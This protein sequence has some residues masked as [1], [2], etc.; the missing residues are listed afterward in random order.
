MDRTFIGW[1]EFL[2]TQMFGLGIGGE[3]R[4]L[5]TAAITTHDPA[6]WCGNNGH[7]QAT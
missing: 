6:L 2:P 3:R 5:A 4:D 7:T 1:R